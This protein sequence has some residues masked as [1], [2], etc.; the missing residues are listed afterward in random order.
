M[1]NLSL[2]THP[3][4]VTV[5]MLPALLVTLAALVALVVVGAQP[6]TAWGADQSVEPPA[7]RPSTQFTFYATGFDGSE[8][9]AYWFSSPD[10]KVYGDDVRY[11]VLA[12]QG[13]ADWS[14]RSPDEATPGTWMAVAKGLHSDTKQVIPFEIVTDAQAV[15]ENRPSVP[16]TNEPGVAVQPESGPAGTMFS[17]YATDFNDG[18]AVGY[19]F[20]APDGTLHSNDVEYRS[21]SYSGRADWQWM[22]PANAMPGTWTV[23]VQGT[24]S[25]TTR[26]IAFEIRENDLASQG[27]L[28]PNASNVAVEP[29]DGPPGGRFHF[30]AAGFRPRETVQ[31]WAFAPGGENYEKSKYTIV[32]NDQGEAYWNWLTPE[33][34][35]LGVWTMNAIGETSQV[36]RTIYFQ[37]R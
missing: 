25:H 29:Q 2:H 28:P 26:V 9:V 7:G 36:Q 4:R 16:L 13:R 14:W 21:R 30:F 33:D 5:P 37:V 15:P 27:I 34:A 3:Y 24:E 19:W 1:K 11:R 35:A 31:F 10:G 6:H 20:N 12:Y 18:E 17:F 8:E 23:V 32:A 22:S